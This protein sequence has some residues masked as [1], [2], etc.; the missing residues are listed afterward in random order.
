M[1]VRKLRT[2]VGQA[3][4][5]GALIGTVVVANMRR[6]IYRMHVFNESNA[7]NTLEIALAAGGAP[8]AY[9]YFALVGDILW[10]PEDDITEDSQPLFEVAGGAQFEATTIVA[11]STM[12][13]TIW[14]EDEY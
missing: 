5:A 9:Y 4:A 6:Y 3:T 13:V 10:V 14:Y 2:A 1:T 12:R 8:I 11:A 7:L